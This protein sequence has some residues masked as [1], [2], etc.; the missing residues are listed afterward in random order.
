VY[1]YKKKVRGISF[2]LFD[3]NVHDEGGRDLQAEGGEGEAEGERAEEAGDVDEAVRGRIRNAQ[4]F[5]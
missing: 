4:D 3:L 5:F 1:G 2:F